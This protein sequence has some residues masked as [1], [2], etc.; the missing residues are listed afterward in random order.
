MTEFLADI[1]LTVSISI[2][3]P[4]FLKTQ[5]GNQ[6]PKIPFDPIGENFLATMLLQYSN[7]TSVR[8]SFFHLIPSQFIYRAVDGSLHL[9]DTIKTKKFN[10]KYQI[11]LQS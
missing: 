4:S 7:P 1:Q 9:L 6:P 2:A 8:W 5:E 11:L 10:Y 3:N